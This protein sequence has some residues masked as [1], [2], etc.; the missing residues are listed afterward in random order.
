MNNRV[1]IIPVVYYS[2]ST[3]VVEYSWQHNAC[4]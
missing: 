4:A 3:R 1:K 2:S